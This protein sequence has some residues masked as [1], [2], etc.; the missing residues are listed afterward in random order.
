MPL[1]ETETDEKGR[2]MPRR[3]L[4]WLGAGWPALRTRF[5]THAAWSVAD[6]PG[7]LGD[8]HAAAKQLAVNSLASVIMLNRGGR[9]ETRRLPAE[10]QWSTVFGLSVADFDGDGSEDLFLAQNF[11]DMRVEEPR[12]DA[13]RGLWLRGDGKGNFA[14]MSAQDSGVMIHG[15]QRGSAVGDFDEDGRPD[16]VVMQAGAETKLFRNERARPG[17][18]VR[19]KGPPGNPAGIGATVGLKFGSRTGPVR[20]IHGGSGYWSQDSAT[21]V[22]AMPENP[23]SIVVRWPGGKLT[24]T[25]VAAGAREMSISME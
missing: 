18:R 10:V 15:Q 14:A 11:F 12:L 17:L 23:T 13:G 22:L 2:L 9:F 19:L 5:A 24:T 1:L 20:E 16:L 25:A 4:N 6:V 21:V 7:A 3:D 8:A